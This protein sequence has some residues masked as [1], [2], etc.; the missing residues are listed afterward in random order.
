MRCPVNAY[1]NFI[2]IR[3]EGTMHVYYEREEA[4]GR[5]RQTGH[6]PGIGIIGHLGLYGTFPLS[7]RPAGIY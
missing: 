4:Y 3:E 6:H 1:P 5:Q 2:A 7:P